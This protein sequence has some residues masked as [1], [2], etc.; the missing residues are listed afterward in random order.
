MSASRRRFATYVSSTGAGGRLAPAL[1]KCA[2]SA[3]P[4]VSARRRR[5]SSSV[6]PTLTRLLYGERHRDELGVTRAARRQLAAHQRDA[7]HPQRAEARGARKR[8]REPRL[9]VRLAYAA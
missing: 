9:A 1:L 3:H 6:K 8:V 2:T 7:L 5:I 4:G